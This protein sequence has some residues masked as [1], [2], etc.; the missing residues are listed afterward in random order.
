MGVVN[1][2]AYPSSIRPLGTTAR[3]VQGGAGNSLR[4][5]LLACSPARNDR[6]VE[7]TPVLLDIAPPPTTSHGANPTATVDEPELFVY[8]NLANYPG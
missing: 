8:P 4:S 1:K 2:D 3:I 6:T 5:T 7:M